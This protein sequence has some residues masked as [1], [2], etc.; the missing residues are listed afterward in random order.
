[1]KT[2][3]SAGVVVYTL[4]EGIPHYLLL[5]NAKGHWDF[6][7]GNIEKGEDRQTSALRELQEE[8]GITAMVHDGFEY[9]YS[10]FLID[11]EG[12]KAYKTV[13]FFVGQAK[14]TEVKLSH[15]HDDFVWL[16]LDEAVKK[17]TFREGQDLLK[18]AHTFIKSIK[19]YSG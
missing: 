10:Y 9:S 3:Q 5:H 8:A 19:S 17:V 13:Y 18:E 14:S 7:K 4:T 12:K 11:Y 2:M 6:A 15:E 1:M 16:P